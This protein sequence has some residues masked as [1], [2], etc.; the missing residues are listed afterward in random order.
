[1]LRQLKDRLRELGQT[2]LLLWMLCSLFQQTGTIPENLGLVFREFTQGYERFLK[3]DV[4]IESA[5]AW[6]KPVL[7]QL[8]WVMMQ[9]EKPTEFRVAISREEAVRAIALGIRK[10]AEEIRAKKLP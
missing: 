10:A 2:P 3:E 8:A 7:Q 9:G 5:R 4:R 6:W 1:M